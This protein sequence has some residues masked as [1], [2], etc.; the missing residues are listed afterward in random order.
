MKFETTWK[1]IRWIPQ[2]VS[3]I[4]EP[5]A[6]YTF[7]CLEKIAIHYPKALYYPFQI[8]RDTYELK[9]RNMAKEDCESVEKIL[10][11][12]RS[13]IMDEFINELKRLSEP[14]HIVKDFMERVNVGDDNNHV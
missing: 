8:P 7:P 13:P 9:K 10:H 5:I 3:L 14:K 4:A 12:I 2:L 11:L 1:L 6:K